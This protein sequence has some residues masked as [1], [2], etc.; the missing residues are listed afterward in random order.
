MEHVQGLHNNLRKKVFLVDA[1]GATVS[2]GGL[3]AVYFSENIFGM[4]H[5][6]TRLIIGIGVLLAIYSF[7]CYY[8]N[9]ANWRLYLRITALLNISY[10]SF[11]AFQ[12]A[13]NARSLT[14]LGYGYFIGE[15]LII[16]LLSA[17]EL[18]LA[19]KQFPGNMA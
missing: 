15:I 4:P 3:L 14:C 12:I 7:S 2:V 8:L 13:E 17:Y 6:E 16:L 5:E 18:Y 10:C 19:G 9:P 1:I 11:T